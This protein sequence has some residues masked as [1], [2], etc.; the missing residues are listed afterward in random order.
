MSS[1]LDRTSLSTFSFG[2]P[3]K[4]S[5]LDSKRLALTVVALETKIFLPHFSIRFHPGVLVKF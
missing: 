1:T 2:R 3:Q 4:Q 5:K